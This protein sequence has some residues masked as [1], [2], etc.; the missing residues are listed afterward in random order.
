[1]QLFCHEFHRS[2]NMRKEHPVTI[3]Q[4]IQTRLTLRS[5]RKPVFRTFTPA[6]EEDRAFTAVFRKL[7]LFIPSKLSL[8][9]T[10]N[11]LRERNCQDIAQQVVLV[12]KMIA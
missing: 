4:I 2:V 7:F 6:R 9:F 8:S 5:Y 11:Q 3:A 1:M 10:V 12:D